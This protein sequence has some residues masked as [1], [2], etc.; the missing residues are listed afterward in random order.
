MSTKY[1]RTID[2]QNV[3]EILGAR[4]QNVT[5]AQRT[6]LAGSLGAGNKGLFVFD[7]DLNTPYIWDGAAF[8]D[9]TASVP[10]AMTY[11]GA[12]SDLVNAPVSPVIGDVYVFTA[13]GTITWAGETISPSAVVEVGDSIIYRGSNVWDV[14]QKNDVQATETVM[15]NVFLAT[16]AEVNAGTEASDVVTPATLAGY[17]TNKQLA[18]VYYTGAINLPN[19]TPTN[20]VHSLGLSA[21]NAFIVR[22]ADSAGS[23]I[24]VDVDAVDANTISLTAT[25]AVTGAIV[26]VIGF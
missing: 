7:T 5:T 12:W 13:A 21:A 6:T 8:V 11:K 26:T 20:V 23:E 14:Y 24:E 9:Y 22:V 1:N 25:P 3:N 4:Q 18:R 10:G 16:Q 15:G 17:A 2:L 19:N